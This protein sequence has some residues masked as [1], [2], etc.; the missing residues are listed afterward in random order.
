[1]KLCRPFVLSR[2]RNIVCYLFNAQSINNKLHELHYLLYNTDC[3]FIFI[4]ESWL[5]ADIDS[6]MLDPQSHF[7]V[8]RNDR[9]T[10]GGGVCVFVKKCWTAVLQDL[11]AP[12]SQL[13]MVCID[14]VN[15]KPKIRFFVVY[16]PPYYDSCAE[17]YCTSLT[18]CLSK[19]M[20]CQHINIILGDINLPKI[21]WIFLTS[22][23][24]VIHRQFLSFVI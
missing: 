11:D 17:L 6:N 5:T 7:D 15:V 20:S 22:P 16:R 3:D 8:F 1:M 21:D 24:D 4:T 19:L 10:H 18:K 12:Y 9:S 14:I 13:E 23:E 2:Y